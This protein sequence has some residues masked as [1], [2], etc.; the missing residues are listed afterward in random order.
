MIG[1]ITSWKEAG[2]PTKANQPPNPP[3][4]QG[5]TI[6]KS[7]TEYQF[8]IKTDDPENDLIYYY[9]NWSDGQTT[10]TDPIKSGEEIILN[11]TWNDKGKYTIKIKAYD[12][13]QAQSNWTTYEIKIIK[14]K[15]ISIINDIILKSFNYNIKYTLTPIAMLLL[16]LIKK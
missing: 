1:G 7:G 11:H 16:A 14:T 3:D 10:Y 8:T 4:I 13:Y 15:T 12:Y 5:K 6:G 2:Y 9:V